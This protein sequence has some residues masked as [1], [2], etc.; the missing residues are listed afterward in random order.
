MIS[1][2]PYYDFEIQSPETQQNF[3]GMPVN[4]A[5]KNG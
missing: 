5:E 4:L 2:N 3:P 1:S